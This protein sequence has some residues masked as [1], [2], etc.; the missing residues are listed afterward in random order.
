MIFREN[1]TKRVMAATPTH[2]PVLWL[3]VDCLATG[4]DEREVARANEPN[5][6]GKNYE[7]HCNIVS[8]CNIKRALTS[9]FDFIETLKYSFFGQSNF[10]Y[11]TLMYSINIYNIHPL[12]LS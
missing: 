6:G 10:K 9:I 8:H 5:S 4:G 12:T 3:P 1:Y 7:V 11:K 2:S